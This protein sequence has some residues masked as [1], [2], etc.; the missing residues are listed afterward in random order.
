MARN[1][2]SVSPVQDLHQDA[3]KTL[4]RP[5][6]CVQLKFESHDLDDELLTGDQVIVL[7]QQSVHPSLKLLEQSQRLVERSGVGVDSLVHILL[8]CLQDF[9]VSLHLILELLKAVMS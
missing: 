4:Q 7:L 2:A 1:K 3:G 9:K 5:K 8:L 6:T